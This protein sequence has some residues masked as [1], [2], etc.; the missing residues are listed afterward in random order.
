VCAY[1]CIYVMPAGW[2]AREGLTSQ[3]WL[4]E[5]TYLWTIPCKLLCVHS[6]QIMLAA[7]SPE[8]DIL[9]ALGACTTYD[10][11]WLHITSWLAHQF[12]QALIQ[13]LD[14]FG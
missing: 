6:P 5:C 10:G 12:D 8:S 13:N 7:Q 4:S 3:Q 2:K 11:I 9:A 14:L 1:D